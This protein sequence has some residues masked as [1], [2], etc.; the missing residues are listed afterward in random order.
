MK[1]TVYILI[2]IFL[3]SS[4]TAFGETLKGTPK[5]EIIEAQQ[6]ETQEAMDAAKEAKPEIEARPAAITKH[7]KHSEQ[8]YKGE[9]IKH[10]K[11][12]THKDIK[13]AE[14]ANKPIEN[15]LPAAN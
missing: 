13:D 15:V 14:A 2:A 8:S 5:K 10:N 12:E 7:K 6:A 4:L 3:A 9:M 11:K 1:T